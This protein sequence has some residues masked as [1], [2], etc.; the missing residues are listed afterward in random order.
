MSDHES[1]AGVEVDST[2]PWWGEWTLDEGETRW[3]A[4]GAL[5]V[6]VHRKAREWRVGYEYFA[7]GTA[8]LPMSE[9]SVDE[10]KT[11]SR[12][13]FSRTGGELKISPAL[14]D[15]AVVTR[16]VSPLYLPPGEETLMYVSSQ[17]WVR[18]EAVDPGKV[19]LDVPSVRPSDTW[20]GPS[21]RDGELCYASKTHA[22]L[23]L[24][25]L[26]RQPFRAVTPLQ[27]VNESDSEM[28]LERVSLPVTGLTL[29]ASEAGELWTQSV[30]MRAGR[31]RQLASLKLKDQPPGQ[32]ENPVVVSAPRE[33][34]H[35]RDLVRAFSSIFT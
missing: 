4:L 35:E 32:I 12:Y 2:G 25:D 24:E 20:F 34:H 7:E 16:P 11:A 33:I 5:L 22:R 21:T 10:L 18:V 9:R 8:M 3:W 29:Y 26:P 27:I 15:R 19:L 30:S 31:D 1:S 6:G 14:A 13:I 23:V 28:M 17:A